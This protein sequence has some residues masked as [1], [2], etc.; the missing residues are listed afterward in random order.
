M[1]FWED[2]NTKYGFND[3]SAYPEGVEIYRDIYCKSVNKLAADKNSEFRVVPFD[4]HGVHNF[5]L[6]FLVSKT[7]FENVFLPQ[8]KTGE[9]WISVDVPND[10][11]TPDEAFESAVEDAM[12][13]DIDG[14]VEVNVTVSDDFNKFLNG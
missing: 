2:M 7:W 10:E 11:Q 8:Q 13:L 1:K 4:R 9:L 6:W 12:E 5:C 14:F 3:G